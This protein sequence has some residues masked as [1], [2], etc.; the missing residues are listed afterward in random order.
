MLL[1]IIKL[2]FLKNYE[3]INKCNSNS[4]SSSDVAQLIAENARLRSENEQ[5][6]KDK[7]RA[8]A[9]AQAVQLQ[10][11]QSRTFHVNYDKQVGASISRRFRENI[12]LEE[13]NKKLRNA[14]KEGEA[15]F[16]RGSTERQLQ[17]EINELKRRLKTERETRALEREQYDVRLLH[18]E[19]ELQRLN[20]SQNVPAHARD[21]VLDGD[22]AGAIPAH[23]GGGPAYRMR[24]DDPALVEFHVLN[25]RL[26]SAGR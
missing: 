14:L 20:V 11:E 23:L 3:Y 24:D 10:Y 1:S 16:P 21:E 13:E 17:A 26:N 18:N 15:A 19:R 22:V 5:L 2:V 9:H 8:N 6:R 25:D 4:I 12:A 7:E